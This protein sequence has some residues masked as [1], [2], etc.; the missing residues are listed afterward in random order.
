MQY[1]CKQIGTEELDAAATAEQKAQDEVA[2]LQAENYELEVGL[3]RAGQ[4]IEE[5]RQEA[6]SFRVALEHFCDWTETVF[7]SGLVRWFAQLWA[8][9]TS[10]A[11]MEVISL[12]QAGIA[13]IGV[14][15][16]KGD[17]KD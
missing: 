8:P 6:E 7:R 15:L 4:C 11:I 13:R 14:I 5:L 3:G 1:I 16:I 9:K 10:A 12:H 2:K 17:V